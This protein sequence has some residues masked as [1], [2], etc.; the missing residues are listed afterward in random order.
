MVVDHRNCH[1]LDE[2]Q[3]R[4]M[5]LHVRILGEGG[6]SGVELACFCAAA[7]STTFVTWSIRSKDVRGLQTHPL[8]HIQSHTSQT[9]LIMK[10]VIA[11]QIQHMTVCGVS[12]AGGGGRAIAAPAGDHHLPFVAPFGLSLRTREIPT[13]EAAPCRCVIAVAH[14]SRTHE[15]AS[16]REESRS[17]V[18]PS[19]LPGA[20]LTR[21]GPCRSD[22]PYNDARLGRSR[23]VARSS[24]IPTRLRQREVFLLPAVLSPRYRRHRSA[25]TG[26]ADDIRVPACRSRAPDVPSHP[27][28]D[29]A[30]ATLLFRK[31]DAATMSVTRVLAASQRR[32]R[33]D[34]A[35]PGSTRKR[36]KCRKCK[37]P[38]TSREP[39]A[40]RTGAR[41]VAHASV[42]DLRA[43]PTIGSVVIAPR[44]TRCD[45]ALSYNIEAAP[46]HGAF[47]AGRRN[48]VI[49]FRPH[50]QA[51]PRMYTRTGS[52]WR[53]T[54]GR[55]AVEELARASVTCSG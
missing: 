35:A 32:E 22:E 39:S 31:D 37:S 52:H 3:Q 40:G 48:C 54:C 8:A 44:T 51:R 12:S 6:V 47:T 7:E 50:G 49:W 16:S 20:R 17:R 24:P 25:S 38:W 2:M 26:A 4:K 55:G 34:G 28:N 9:Y 33:R 46:A 36:R 43:F 1:T 18:R 5:L 21:P 41:A 23:F 27:P 15:L 53:L 42:N 30:S 11:A 45:R 14:D 29:C 10:V 13:P 19:P